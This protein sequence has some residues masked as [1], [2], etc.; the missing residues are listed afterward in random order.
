VLVVQ[1]TLGWDNIKGV[2][3]L[4]SQRIIKGVAVTVFDPLW[5][6][7]FT[8]TEV[9]YMP[10]YQRVL[11]EKLMYQYEFGCDK[12]YIFPFGNEGFMNHSFDPNVNE[13]GISSRVIEYG[14][15]LTCD[16]TLLDSNCIKGSEPWLS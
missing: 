7:V 11:V 2:C 13:F 12:K 3:V 15:E 4:A 9:K 1:T 6:K 10:H 5:D 14:D 16:Y 8:S